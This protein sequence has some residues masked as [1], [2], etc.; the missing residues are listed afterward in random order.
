MNLKDPL[1]TIS[2]SI[3]YWSDIELERNIETI[4]PEVMAGLDNEIK[5]K[6]SLSIINQIK[7]RFSRNSVLFII[8]FSF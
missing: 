2:Y 8:A 7:S 5:Q 6:L 1:E 3:S 4:L